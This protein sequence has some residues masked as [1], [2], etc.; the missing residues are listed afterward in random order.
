MRVLSLLPGAT[1]VVHALGLGDRLVGVTHE[2]DAPGCAR[3]PRVTASAVDAERGAG[4]VDAEVRALSAEGSAIFALDEGRIATLAPDVVLTQQLCEVCAVSE[5][6]VRAL[7][8]RIGTVRI[9][10]LAATTLDGV[11]DD[12]R[13]V[14]AVL[15]A[16]EA[17]ERLVADARARL[18]AVHDT[19]KA[20]GAPRPRVAVIEWGEPV[21]AAGH[22]VP[23]MVRRA[24]GADVLAQPGEHSTTRTVAQVRDAAPE[25]VLIS[26]CG[27]DAGRAEREA[28]RLLAL[29]DWAW[30][31]DRRVWAIDA[32]R[33]VSR[34][35]PLLADGI[36]T[37]AAILAPDL[38][39]TPSPT[40]ARRVA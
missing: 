8:A 35:G 34:P 27:Y 16:A 7:A 14:A 28:R 33:L 24:G 2:C 11:W 13:R 23:E 19:L 31:R 10:T 32:N 36:A 9:V 22:W 20:A 30:A 17:G 21:Y 4:E 37:M 26:P 18:G 15:D 39:P 3:L 1:D 12:V 40:D 38:F 6:Q 25:V 5:T 29:D